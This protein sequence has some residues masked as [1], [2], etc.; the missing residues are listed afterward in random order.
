MTVE[1]L[2]FAEGRTAAGRASVRLELPTG[3]SIDDLWGVVERACPA[4]LRFRAASRIAVNREFADAATRIREGD[5][6]ALIPPVSG[7]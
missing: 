1:L 2:L 4:L 3:A 6:V 7:G 5:E